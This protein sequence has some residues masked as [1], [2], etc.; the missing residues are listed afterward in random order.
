MFNLQNRIALVTGGGRGIGRAIA[1]DLAAAGARV[2]VSARSAGE[3]DEVVGRIRAQGGQAT[4]IVADLSDRQA[5]RQVIPQVTE[6]VGPLDILVN[7]AG[8]GSSSNPKAVLH[9]DDDFWE[10]TL[11]LNLTVPYLLS[12]A[13]LPA[14]LAKKWGRIINVSSIN[15]KVP[16]LHGAAYAASKHGLLGLTKTLALEVARDG[17]TV[18]AICPGPVH[19]V[20]SDKRMDYDAQRRSMSLEELEA[21]VTPM[22]RRLEPEE[23][24]PLAVYLASDEAKMVTGQ[25][26]NV[27]G[28]VTMF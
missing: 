12:K 10:L 25:G 3:L 16:S 4:A 15:G 8:I 13:A 26:W 7:N 11:W 14:M 17:I 1:L 5:V 18:N 19:T 27:C 23:V 6:A 20:M 22:G 2:A 9:F 21:A 24:S 28:G